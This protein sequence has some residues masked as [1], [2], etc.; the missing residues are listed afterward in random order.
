MGTSARAPGRT[1]T[2]WRFRGRNRPVRAAGPGLAARAGEAGAA[3]GAGADRRVRR[4]GRSRQMANKTPKDV[5]AFAK[6]KKIQMIDLKFLDFVG[7]WQHFSIPL[8]E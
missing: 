4:E 7:I 8:S 6:D 3:V 5:V 2:R 1:G